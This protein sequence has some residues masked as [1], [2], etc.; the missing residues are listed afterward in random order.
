MPSHVCKKPK[1]EN[2][3]LPT[4]PSLYGL[5]HSPSIFSLSHPRQLAN[6]LHPTPLL[7]LLSRLAL[8]NPPAS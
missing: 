8:P 5:D 1:Q 4:E 3:S 2:N 6:S 7:G